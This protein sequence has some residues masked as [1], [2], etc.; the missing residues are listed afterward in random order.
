LEQPPPADQDPPVKPDEP[1]PDA[2]KLQIE[3]K[4][5][6][7]P[8]RSPG[9]NQKP[10]IQIEVKPA[11]DP[12]TAFEFKPVPA[13]PPTAFEFKPADQRSVFEFKPGDPR[14]A[15]EFRPADQRSAFEPKADARL[16]FE[17][18][19]ELKPPVESRCQFEFCPEPKPPTEPR[20]QIEPK[21]PQEAKLQ[22]EL[23]PSAE[24]R[25]QVEAKPPQEAKLQIEFK[26]PQEPKPEPRSLPPPQSES[27]AF[28]FIF[29]DERKS[30]TAPVIQPDRK[31]SLP[32]R[33]RG[34]SPL[35]FVQ[36]GSSLPKRLA[37][38]LCTFALLPRAV[39]QADAP[40]IDDEEGGEGPQVER[41]DPM[42]DIPRPPLPKP[43]PFS[44]LARK[45]KPT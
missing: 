13:E 37:L 41:D 10:T 12:P 9:F 11:Q 2:P 23:K 45:V 15:F 39:P 5:P 29:L 36:P 8:K 32:F 22:I 38:P 43:L 34:E 14:S 31:P 27:R 18:R 42:I 33:Y 3:V 24:P 1:P 40:D 16:K 6:P 44:L 35:P 17:F 30:I 20:F 7:D 19:S 21:L 26:V 25:F 28:S 4:P